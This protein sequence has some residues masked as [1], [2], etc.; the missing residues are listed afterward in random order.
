MTPV[1]DFDEVASTQSADDAIEHLAENR[2]AVALT[3]AQGT[4]V[5]V[6]TPESVMRWLSG[7]RNRAQPL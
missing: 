4:V 7:V 1:A 6:V 5:R 2:A 3:N